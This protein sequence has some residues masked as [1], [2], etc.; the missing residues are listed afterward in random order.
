MSR[1]ITRRLESLKARRT[2]M[3][4]LNRIAA[5]DQATIILR[6]LLE[7]SYQKRAT[8]KP[9]TRYALGAMQEVGPEYTRISV[10]T[11]ERVQGQLATGLYQTSD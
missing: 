7:E 8:N 3:D 9:Y 11:A 1:N 6:S 2:G 10:E 4:R 5:A